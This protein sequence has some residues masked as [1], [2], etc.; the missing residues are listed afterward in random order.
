MSTSIVRVPLTALKQT[1]LGATCCTSLPHLAALSNEDAKMDAPTTLFA[2]M[3]A[4][5]GSYVY[6]AC[7]KPPESIMSSMN[8]ANARPPFSFFF[9][10]F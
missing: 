6:Q 7:F 10:Y 3:T 5:C 1:Q 8:I 9:I 2:L 4:P